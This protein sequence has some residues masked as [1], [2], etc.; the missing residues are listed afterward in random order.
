MWKFTLKIAALVDNEAA[1]ALKLWGID[2]DKLNNQKSKDILGI[3]YLDI[4]Q[5]VRDMGR[6][7][8]ETGVV[9]KKAKK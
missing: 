7:L 1:V 2:F 6:S 9:P 3:D 4:E 5:A 8:I